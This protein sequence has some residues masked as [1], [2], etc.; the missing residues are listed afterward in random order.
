[1]EK[2]V[3]RESKRGGEGRGR[4]GKKQRG[5]DGIATTRK[6]LRRGGIVPFSPV[7]V[8]KRCVS[9]IMRR[10]RAAAAISTP[11][12]ARENEAFYRVR[13][14]GGR[15]TQEEV[16]AMVSPV[17]LSLRLCRFRFVF[18]SLSLSL[19]SSF[20]FDP[21][22]AERKTCLT[23]RLLRTLRAL[24]FSIFTHTHTRTRTR[25]ANRDLTSTP[26]PSRPRQT[27]PRRPRRRG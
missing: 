12:R 21:E 9:L 1:M 17:S 22:T 24:F 8:K 26:P 18:L 27:C 19:S 14:E 7:S 2:K 11:R 23:P 5:R 4:E 25:T 10:G 6:T 13:K 3:I 20:L 16:G 15:E